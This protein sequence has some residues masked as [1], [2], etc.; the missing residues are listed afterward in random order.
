M[1]GPRDDHTEW[2]KSYGIAYIKKKKYKWAYLQNWSRP[3]DLEKNF[4][5]TKGEKQGGEG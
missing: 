2:R 5:V 3:T 4:I 1:D